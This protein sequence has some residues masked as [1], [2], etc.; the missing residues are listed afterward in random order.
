M[1]LFY[2]DLS[3]FAR[4]VRAVTEEKG[5]A[6][7]ITATPV[8]P[9]E[10]PERLR[11]AN[12]LSKVPTLVLDDGRALYDSTVICEYLDSV[13]GGR[14]LLPAEGE[15]RFDVLRRNALVNG[16]IETAF[17]LACEMHRREPGERSPRWIEH[18]R[19]VI[20]RTV[21]ALEAEIGDWPEALDMAHLTAGCALGYLD[22]RLNEQVDWRAGHPEV[23]A[24]Y[25]AFSRSPAMVASAPK[26]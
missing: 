15:A 24:W 17:A 7:R 22:V 26:V 18:W 12:P 2:A 19:T 9:Y 23:A 8:N 6:E 10:A 21:D 11:A 25:E 20:L 1:E 5:L 13:G 16:I 4:K 3:P 14:R